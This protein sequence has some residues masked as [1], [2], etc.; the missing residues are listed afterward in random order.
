MLDPSFSIHQ[1][2]IY[3]LQF[4]F[5]SVVLR[6]GFV[7]VLFNL[8]NLL[9]GHAFQTLIPHFLDTGPEVNFLVI[10]FKELPFVSG[11]KLEKV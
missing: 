8:I 1:R 5:V 6:L 4:F 3:S 10:Q 7:D 9:P 2:F 11:L